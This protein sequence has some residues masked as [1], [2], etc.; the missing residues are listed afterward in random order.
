MLEGFRGK[1][2]DRRSDEIGENFSKSLDRIGGKAYTARTLLKGK[3][4]RVLTIKTLNMR[5]RDP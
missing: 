1:R 5:H 2:R 4:R 3:P